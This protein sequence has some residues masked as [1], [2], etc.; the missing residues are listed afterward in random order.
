MKEV[1]SFEFVS[2]TIVVSDEPAPQEWGKGTQT[3]P[4]SLSGPRTVPTAFHAL[5]NFLPN[6]V[7]RVVISSFSQW[8]N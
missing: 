3:Y 6:S 8:E 2:P 4:H 1:L 7:E 5:T